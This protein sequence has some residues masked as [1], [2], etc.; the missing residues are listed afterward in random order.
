MA[1][2]VAR[3]G[4]TEEAVAELI[5]G[6]NEPEWVRERRYVVRREF[7]NGPVSAVEV[8]IELEP[9]GDGVI[10]TSFADFI[11]T[12]PAGRVLWRLG[13][14]PV[15]GLLDFCDRYL[16]RKAAGRADPTPTPERRAPVDDPI[17]QPE[18]LGVE[19]PLGRRARQLPRVNEVRLRRHRATR[20]DAEGCLAP[21]RVQV[22]T[23][24]APVDVPASAHRRRPY[25]RANAPRE[26]APQ[27]A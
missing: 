23:E 25:A 1:A 14:A 5:A 6:R 19:P 8:G 20:R 17:H 22:D 2:P 13:K 9:D 15:A 27:R 4:F 12:S 26:A 16:V 11:S 7:E 18:L 10:V 3:R 21:Q 24:R